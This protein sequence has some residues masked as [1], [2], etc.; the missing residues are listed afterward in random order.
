MLEVQISPKERCSD[1]L[2]RSFIGI[3]ST[4][5]FWCVV[6]GKKAFEGYKDLFTL[7]YRRKRANGGIHTR[8]LR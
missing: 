2:F 4:Q 7:N 6:G 8:G 1:L 5:L 3:T